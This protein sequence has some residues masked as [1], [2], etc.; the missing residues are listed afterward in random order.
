MINWIKGLLAA[1]GFAVAAFFA[2]RVS[3]SRKAKEA[4]RKAD[5]RRA[6]QIKEVKVDREE[7]RS[8]DGIALDGLLRKLRDKQD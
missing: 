8:L 4:V 5:Q 2:G 7:I 3:G 6:G 1:L